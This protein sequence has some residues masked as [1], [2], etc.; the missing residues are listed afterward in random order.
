M[1]VTSDVQDRL[2]TKK[3]TRRNVIKLASIAGA[4]IA[5][6]SLGAKAGSAAPSPASGTRSFMKQGMGDDVQTMYGIDVHENP[7]S[8]DFNLNLYAGA[9][10]S[11]VTGLLNFDENM[12]AVGD[13][14]E[15]WEANEDFSVYTFYL[16]PN[17]TG[18][19]DGVAVTAHDFVYSFGRQLDPATGAAYAGFLFDIKNGEA[20]NTGRNTDAEGTPLAAPLTQADLGLKAIDDWTLEVTMEGPR[21]YFPQV[22]AYVAAV[23]A[24]QDLV[25][26]LGDAWA[27]GGD[28]PV[29][30]C[31][32][33]MV[34]S[35]EHGVGIDLVPNP[36]YWNRDAVNLDHLH[37]TIHPAANSLLMFEEGEG[38]ESVDWCRLSAADY[39]R[40]SNDPELSQLVQPFVYPGVWMLLPQVTIAPF[41]D[42]RVRTALSHAI[43]RT[44]LETISLG[45]LSP[46]ACLIP[47]GVFGYLDDPGLAEIQRFDPELAMASLVGTEFEGGQNWPEVTLYMRSNEEQYNAD[48]MANDIVAQIQENLGWQIQIQIVPT[49]NWT[50]QLTQLQ[51]PLV[52]IRWWYDYPDPNNGYGD[53][54]YSRKSSG[55]RQA[56]SN[57]EFDDLVNAGKAEGDNAKR[58]E[59]Y[60]QC[61]TIMQEDRG[62]IP[63]VYRTDMNVFQPWV[64]GMKANE[65]GFLVPDTNIY[66]NL[67]RDVYIEGRPE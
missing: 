47:P 1:D 26:A 57:D 42:I 28:N 49:A 21:G 20:L 6:A 19:S 66:R 36:G 24:R 29:V 27:I 52:M 37:F 59:I 65:G 53:M 7:T 51:W 34:E 31:G 67:Y 60:H 13:W 64:K 17:N 48:I 40:F 18:W 22:V 58:L 61:E 15:R 8:F 25:E 33:F 63:L 62:Y 35:W 30:T 54:F 56:W 14:A 2:L 32:P 5:A 10:T 55:R 16:R 3:T 50:A 11:S 12:V 38:D 39:E 46:A 45:L 44:R 43:D 9:P 4:G 23:P 41:D